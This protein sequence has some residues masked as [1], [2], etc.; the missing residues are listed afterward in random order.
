MI[1][2]FGVFVLMSLLLLGIVRDREQKTKFRQIM[3]MQEK[4][5]NLSDFDF[6]KKASLMPEDATLVSAIR[7]KLAQRGSY[8]PEKIY[9]EDE[10]WETFDFQLGD[11]VDEFATQ[12]IECEY[13]DL[14][15]EELKQVGDLVKCLVDRRKVQGTKK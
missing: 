11:F 2:L 14:P 6:C 7:N 9:P 15:Y 3:A 4:R 13:G 12:F 1:L 5:Q 8:N 10:L